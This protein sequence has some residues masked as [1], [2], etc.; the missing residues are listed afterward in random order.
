M[1]FLLYLERGCEADFEIDSETDYKTD[2]ETEEVHELRMHSA[3]IEQ[4][5]K[6]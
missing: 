3:Y 2:F 6:H 4:K 5:Q 1:E